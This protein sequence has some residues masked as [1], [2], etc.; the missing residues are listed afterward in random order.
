MDWLEV[1]GYIGAFAI[2]FTLVVIVPFIG[3][4]L[5]SMFIAGATGLSGVWWWCVVITTFLIIASIL[6]RTSQ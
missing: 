6:Y 2:M 5:I 4:V 3:A 1:L